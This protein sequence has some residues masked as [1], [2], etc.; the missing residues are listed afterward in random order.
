MGKRVPPL[1]AMAEGKRISEPEGAFLLP[2]PRPAVVLVAGFDWIQGS[3]LIA[4]L[5][6]LFSGSPDP[7]PAKP[8]GLLVPLGMF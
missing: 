4:V 1:R 5:A 2:W 6:V 7:S 8:A 3:L